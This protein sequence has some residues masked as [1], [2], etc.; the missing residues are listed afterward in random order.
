LRYGLSLETARRVLAGWTSQAMPTADGGARC[1]WEFVPPGG[2]DAMPLRL[3]FVN[4]E[5]TASG[6]YSKGR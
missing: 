3:T 4:D 2:S 5:L 6:Q 1:V